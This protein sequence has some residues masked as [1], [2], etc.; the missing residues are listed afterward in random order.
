MNLPNKL[1]IFRILLIPVIILV[2]SVKQLRESFI[3]FPNLSQ[4]NFIIL[5]IMFIGAMTDFLDGHI[6]RRDNLVTNFG[7]FL[8]PIADKMLTF[9]GFI[10][11]ME[12]NS[13]N[14]IISGGTSATLI[15]WWMVLIIFARETIVTGLRL[16][17]VEQ[18]RVIAASKY[19][20]I[21]T[22]LQFI[23]IIFILAGGSVMVVKGELININ[24]VYDIIAKILIIAMLAV[25]IFSGYDY[26]IK[27]KDVLKDLNK[28][29]DK[30]KKN[31]K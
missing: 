29:T 9:T 2:Y 15:T 12:Q 10:V 27:N 7:K 30:K 1:T 5:L 17:A 20:K 21:K 19:G 25:T 18:G 28:K 8:D 3:L 13:Y 14:Q 4:A 24:L 23:T 26:I 11:L 6:A 16:L 22:T 31:K